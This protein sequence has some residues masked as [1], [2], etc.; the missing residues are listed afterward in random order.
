MTKFALDHKDT[1]RYE[2]LEESFRRQSQQLLLDVPLDEQSMAGA[3][4]V[5]HAESLASAGLYLIHRDPAGAESIARRLLTLSSLLPRAHADKAR[6]NANTLLATLFE[7]QGKYDQAYAAYNDAIT[8]MDFDSLGP[9]AP[10]V[11]ETMLTERARLFALH[12]S[13]TDSARTSLEHRL[14]DIMSLTAF[15]WLEKAE[16]FA[17]LLPALE[18]EGL[19]DRRIDALIYFVQHAPDP[20]VQTPDERDR[21][22]DFLSRL[23]GANHESIRRP[24]AAI[25]AYDTLIA[26]ETDPDVRR[27]LSAIRDDIAA[28]R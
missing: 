13:G 20:Q 4:G 1:R 6:L 19:V 5:G 25:F 11:R 9:V 22:L 18:K 7:R 2:E 14:S 15:S 17:S 28:G 24:D 26:R 21:V 3:C 27:R 10:A 23:Q 16:L 8:H 12:R